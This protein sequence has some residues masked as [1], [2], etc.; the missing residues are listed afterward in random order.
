MD[1]SAQADRQDLG[2]IES[3]NVFSQLSGRPIPL[4][5]VADVEI[6]WQPAKIKRRRRL[7]TVTVIADLEPAVTATDVT[8]QLTPWLDRERDDWPLGYGYHLGGEA[9]TS[10]DANASIMVKLPIAG[11][12]ILLLLVGQF[13]SLRRTAIVL[14]TIPLSLIGVE[15]VL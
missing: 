11:L 8:R 2:K 3:L 10:G 14:A 5:Q 4:K 9:E 6:A 7:K 15:P 1:P 12:L 13:N